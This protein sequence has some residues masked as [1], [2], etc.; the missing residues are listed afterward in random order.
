MS[1]DKIDMGDLTW[2]TCTICEKQSSDKICK[3]CMQEHHPKIKKFL[4]D[5]P[6][7][8]YMEAVFSKNLPVSRSIL[9]NFVQQGIVKLK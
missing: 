9:Y 8:T 7:I 3:Y 4:D 1:D 6:G 5:H 2:S